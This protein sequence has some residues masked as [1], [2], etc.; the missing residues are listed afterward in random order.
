[1]RRSRACAVA[2]LLGF[3]QARPAVAFGETAANP[4]GHPARRGH[5]EHQQPARGQCLVNAAKELLQPP[6]R[7]GR[8]EQVIEDFAD[9]RHGH[10][11]RQRRFE[12]R[13]L[14]E[15]GPRH[16]P[17]GQLDHRGG[18]I[19]ADHAVGGRHQRLGQDAAARAQVDHRA[20]AQPAAAKQLDQ[21]RRRRGRESAEAGV[22]N[23][24][25]VAAIT[26]A[27]IVAHR[28]RFRRVKAKYVPKTTTPMARATNVV[29]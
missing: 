17:P 1:M 4:L 22:V 26:V 23:G 3:V 6:R 8:V 11:L 28:V 29:S 21:P 5:V 10:A 13:R 19:E 9:C 14:A 25:Q 15:L 20:L 27:R 7:V 16:A 12:K 24:R 18:N 2:V